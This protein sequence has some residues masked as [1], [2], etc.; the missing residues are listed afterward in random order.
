MQRRFDKPTQW[1][2][3]LAVGFSVGARCLQGTTRLR[4]EMSMAVASRRPGTI[5]MTFLTAALR[6]R[7]A[8]SPAEGRDP[9]HV[10]PGVGLYPTTREH[11]AMLGNQLK[12]RHGEIGLQH[13]GLMATEHQARDA[14]PSIFEN[15]GT[16]IVKWRVDDDHVATTSSIVHFW[17]RCARLG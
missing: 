2:T 10:E 3:S 4:G 6:T 14:A 1:T 9:L 7:G 11:W 8:S 16:V 17:H 5:R 13:G 15:V 12:A